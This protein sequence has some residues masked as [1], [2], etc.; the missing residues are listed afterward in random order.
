MRQ[1]KNYKATDISA[2]AAKYDGMSE[3]ELMGELMKNVAA[4]K[5]NGSFSAEQLDDF[6]Q[7]VAPSLDEKSRNRLT[8]LINAIKQG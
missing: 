3:G 7:F 4:A 6:A 1:L 5:E 8:E 2:S